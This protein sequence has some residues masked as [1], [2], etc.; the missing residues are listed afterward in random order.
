MGEPIFLIS[1]GMIERSTKNGVP[2]YNDDNDTF[3]AII[4]GMSTEL[5][6]IADGK[7]RAK[8]EGAFYNF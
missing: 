6:E 2:T 5:V 4:D 7:Y 1:F 3:I 8:V